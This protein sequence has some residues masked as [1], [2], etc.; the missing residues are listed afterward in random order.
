MLYN[1]TKDISEEEQRNRALK[2]LEQVGLADRVN[3]QPHELSGGQAREW[4]SPEPWS[5]NGLDPGG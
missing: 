5:T 2:A 4:L 3:H 1:T